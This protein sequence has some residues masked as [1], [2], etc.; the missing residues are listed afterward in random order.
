MP[1][2]TAQLAEIDRKIAAA[3]ADR[4]RLT[5]DLA[6]ET[7]RLNDA[8]ADGAPDADIQ[9]LRDAL[10]VLKD[11]IELEAARVDAL[12]GKRSRI[13]ADAQ[14]AAEADDWDKASHV[15]E[16]RVGLASEI[17][18]LVTDLGGAVA[19]L[20]AVTK[21]VTPIMPAD[22]RPVLNG[23]DLSAALANSLIRAGLGGLFGV[24]S[25]PA[26]QRGLAGTVA[27]DNDRMLDNWGRRHG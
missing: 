23:E 9:R 11:A 1:D 14:K 6:T 27:D 4:A 21:T 3:E 18:K 19:K 22:K 26:Q 8:L 17:E 13:E 5:A 2:F 15:A 16:T 24:G 7:G 25:V 20:D 10:Q 12:R